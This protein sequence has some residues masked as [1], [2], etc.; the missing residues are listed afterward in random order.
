MSLRHTKSPHLGSMPVALASGPCARFFKP[1]VPP[2]GCTCQGRPAGG[3]S[4]LRIVGAGEASA[5]VWL[6]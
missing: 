6:V 5:S 3:R 4:G 2:R 1:D